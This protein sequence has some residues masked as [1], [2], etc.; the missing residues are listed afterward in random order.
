MLP[1]P[2]AAAG[3]AVMLLELPAAFLVLLYVP[4]L[5]HA[6]A[7]ALLA[8]QLL[9]ISWGPAGMANLAA[10]VLSFML[11]DEA[12][13]VPV[14]LKLARVLGLTAG[15]G[16][17]MQVEGGQQQLDNAARPAL[18]R[19]SSV[20]SMVSV[21]V[22]GECCHGTRLTAGYRAGDRTQSVCCILRNKWGRFGC[23]VTIRHRGYCCMTTLLS[24]LASLLATTTVLQRL[25]GV[26]QQVP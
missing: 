10:A 14:V 20:T 25:L 4:A 16:S 12:R 9:R 21:G 6:T 11:L 17:S 24:G 7:V 3:T 26:P 5:Q 1:A 23:R 2:L 18:S 22:A 13:W 8:L 15:Q 19:S